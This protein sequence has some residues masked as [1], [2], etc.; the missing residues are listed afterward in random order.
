MFSRARV[1]QGN[2]LDLSRGGPLNTR[3][4]KVLGDAETDFARQPEVTDGRVCFPHSPLDLA[5]EQGGGSLEDV[6]IG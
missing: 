6:S 5:E 3:R 1:C 2:G 4:D